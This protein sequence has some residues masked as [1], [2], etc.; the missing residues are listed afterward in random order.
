MFSLL[1]V[2]C[3]V[4][5]RVEVCCS[6]LQCVKER[7][8]H[9]TPGMLQ[10]VAVCCIVSGSAMITALPVYCSLLQRNVVCCSMLQ[11]VKERNVHFTPGMLQRV[12]AGC[13][14]LQRVVVCQ[15]AQFSPYSRYVAAC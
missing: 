6:V 1:P 12:A 2:R 8:V 14:V 11:C 7:N 5:Q 3:C 4:L 10:R 13:S 15:E 9:F